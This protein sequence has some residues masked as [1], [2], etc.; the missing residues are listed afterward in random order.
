MKPIGLENRKKSIL[1]ALLLLLPIILIILWN[2]PALLKEEDKID[3]SPLEVAAGESTVFTV[4]TSSGNGIV[5]LPNNTIPLFEEGASTIRNLT[6]SENEFVFEIL[7]PP[8]AGIIDITVEAGDSS[9]TFAINVITA[10]DPLISGKKI[11][12]RMDYVTTESNR[13]FHRVT[14][15]PQLGNGA[16][17]FRDVFRDF[18]LE[19][20][21]VAYE[22][23]LSGDTLRDKAR[24]VLVWNVVAYR[25]GRNTKEWIVLGG[26]YDMSPATIEGAYDNTAG[27]NTVVEIARGLS[28]IKTNKT[29][30][31]GLW[32][33]EE[34]GLL[35]A[36]EFVESIPDDVEVKTYLN[37]D[38]VGI[39]YPAPYSLRAIVGPDEDPEVIE[40]QHLVNLTNRTAQEILGYPYPEGV[41]VYEESHRGSDH[42]RF[43]Q[44]G[45]PIVF[46]Y[47]Q[48]AND[49]DAYHTRDDTLQEMESVA[50][51]KENLEAGFDTVAWMGFYLTLLLDDDNIVHQQI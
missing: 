25:W 21:V 11:Y 12:E 14:G 51:G 36:Q 45:V 40:N 29:I 34:E 13:I 30:V 23:P 16:L 4:K 10:N 18:G 38:M 47:G 33:G 44:I 1:I 41:D 28:Q 9:K 43:E 20:E 2:A 26:H 39:N 5:R 7:I 31:F 37:F 35:G 46:F 32:S 6:F 27:T 50:G 48:S 17:Y 49:Y 19:A 8:N 42:Y 3:L 15:H 22:V 24:G